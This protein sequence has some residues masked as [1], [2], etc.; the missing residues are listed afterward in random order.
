M[1]DLG[2]RHAAV[3]EHHLVDAPLAAQRLQFG[4]VEE[5]RSTPEF[6]ILRYRRR[7]G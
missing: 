4:L 6:K 2:V 5:F 1:H 3:G 7:A